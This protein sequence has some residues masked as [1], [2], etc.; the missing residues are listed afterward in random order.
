MEKAIVFAQS[1]YGDMSE[2]DFLQAGINLT[3]NSQ[4]ASKEREKFIQN[5]I[6]KYM[7]IL[8][9]CGENNVNKCIDYQVSSLDKK[10]FKQLMSKGRM[11]ITSDGTV[12]SI[13][14]DDFIKTDDDGTSI[15]ISNGRLLITIDLNGSAPPNI[16]GR[17][18]FIIAITSSTKNLSLFGAG[19]SRNDLKNHSN[20]G[21]NSITSK[22][23]YCGA[24]ILQDGWVI[25]DDYLWR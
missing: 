9:D 6:I 2:W 20:W 5:Y 12:Y 13:K 1:E 7:Q 11:F 22:R 4:Y 16:F 10:S 19:E 3:E 23:Y 24:L 17:D 14:F 15:S 25:K 8:K 21:C 18:L